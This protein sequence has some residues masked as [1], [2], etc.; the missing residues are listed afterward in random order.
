MIALYIIDTIQRDS[1]GRLAFCEKVFCFVCL[2]YLRALFHC[3]TMNSFFI[4][5]EFLKYFKAGIASI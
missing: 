1:Y 3:L 4:G 2:L 5:C